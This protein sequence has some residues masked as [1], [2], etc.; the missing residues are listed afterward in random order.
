MALLLFGK[1]SA[2]LS[3]FELIQAAQSLAELTG[4]RTPGT[5]VLDRL[6]TGLGLDR[7]SIDSSGSNAGATTIGAGRYVAP[8]IYVGAKQG[9]SATSSRG[10]VE[11]EVFKH[12]KIEGDVG[13]DSQGRVGVKMEWDY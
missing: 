8:G 9:A 7:L 10:V 12:T 3:P 13:A 1:S 4:R 2:S 5:G 6:R 11:I